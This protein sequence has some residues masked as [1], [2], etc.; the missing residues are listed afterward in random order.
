[1]KH[2]IVVGGGIAGLS[3]AYQIQKKA[4]E[5]NIPH[6]LTVLEAGS[7][8]GG[9][10][11]TDRV[12]GFVVEGGPDT[13]IVTKPWA[14]Q[15][16]KE[17]GL[18]ERLKGTN[19]H[20]KNTYILHDQ[21]LHPLPGGLTM[22]IPTEFGPMIRT[23]LLSWPAKIRM[24]MDF[25]LPPAAENGDESLGEFVTRRLG[26]Q[27]Y[28]RLIEPLMS[29]IYAG[30]GDKLSL[31]ATFPY[32]RDL[33]LEHGG[34][35]KGAL[36][37]RHQRAQR[38]RQEGKNNGHKSPPGSRSIFLTPITGLAEI[39]EALVSRLEAGG[40]DMLLNTQ[41][42]QIAPFGDGFSLFLNEGE[43]I[44]SDGLVLA[45]PAYAS[46]DLIAGFAPELASEL[47]A[48]EYVSTATVSLAYRE[49]DL[50]RPLDGYGYVIPR[51]EGQKALACTWTST[52]FPHRAPQGYAL[53]RVFIGRAGQE[54]DLP[55]DEVG[56]QAIAQE[57]V[58]QTLGITAEPQL[59]RVYRWEKA[60]PQFNIGHPARLE[61][62][63]ALVEKTPGLGL[64]GNGYQG[65][66][67]PDCIHSGELAADRVLEA[68]RAPVEETLPHEL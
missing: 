61:R 65:I 48:I 54:A 12:D 50:K 11:I 14:V 34:L 57:E 8:W 18:S 35:V 52:K 26:R 1:M 41:V 39:V 21:H 62:I 32:L 29:G 17:L 64:A 45:T 37:L 6:Q 23:G 5:A 44:F 63:D 55:W 24:G 68:M 19:P 60:M 2:I 4:I 3:A 46:G 42:Q 25:M 28:E 38:Q 22:M 56:L 20:Q 53:V 16:C 33:E 49:A 27:A 15:L 66:G 13:F 31:Q 30:D 7:Y 10:I 67:I 43:T 58:R 59:A 47:Q 40:A 9:K 51:R 36:A